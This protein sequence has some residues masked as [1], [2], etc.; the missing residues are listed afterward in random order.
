MSIYIPETYFFDLKE[1]EEFILHKL[2]KPNKLPTV[3]LYCPICYE[4]HFA[5][6]AGSVC[7]IRCHPDLEVIRISNWS[8]P[9]VDVSKNKWQ[10][11]VGNQL[12][13]IIKIVQNIDDANELSKYK[14]FILKK[15]MGDIC[16]ISMINTKGEGQNITKQFD[17]LIS[18]YIG[19]SSF[20]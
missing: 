8:Y 7:K 1:D 10:E 9:W 20:W 16:R 4:Q 5:P 17:P 12:F 2:P 13:E 18:K 6:P 15:D 14:T 11:E 19:M 3:S